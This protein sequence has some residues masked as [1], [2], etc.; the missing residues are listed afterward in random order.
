MLWFITL[1]CLFLVLFPYENWSQYFK[2]P[3]LQKELK[4]MYDIIKGGT[5]KAVP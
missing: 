3:F 5:P 2:A 1:P 4:R